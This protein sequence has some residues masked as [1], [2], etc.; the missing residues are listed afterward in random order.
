MSNKVQ[1]ALKK[2]ISAQLKISRDG[3]VVTGCVVDQSGLD[4]RCPGETQQP[5]LGVP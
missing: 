2:K 3:C 5:R 1:F 4:C